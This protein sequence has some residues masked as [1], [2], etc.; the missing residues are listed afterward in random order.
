M[1]VLHSEPPPARVS[2]EWTCAAELERAA[3]YVAGVRRAPTR[4]A[5]LRE[6]TSYEGARALAALLRRLPVVPAPFTD[7]AC[8]QE[9]R[10]WFRPHRRLPLDRAPVAVLALPPSAAEYLRGRPRQALR[11]NM[12]RASDAGIV[13]TLAHDPRELRRTITHLATSRGQ[14]A[15]QMISPEARAGLR[16]DFHVAYD[17]AGDPVALSETIV[18][19]TW[20]GVGALV[21]AADHPDAPNTR[22]LLH[23]HLVGQLIDRGVHTLTVGGSMLLTSEGTRYFQRRTGFT[24]VWLR[25]LPHPHRRAR[26]TATEANDQRDRTWER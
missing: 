1:G 6:M 21:S 13:C 2:S 25:V 5:K 15:T 20:A 23:V 3:R 18:D 26:S 22:Y 16:R 12:K 19:H 8:G 24:P 10:S 17:A 14:S 9:L 7:D 11:T 4:A